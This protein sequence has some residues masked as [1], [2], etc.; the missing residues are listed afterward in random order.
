VFGW[1]QFALVFSIIYHKQEWQVFNLHLESKFHNYYYI[2][3]EE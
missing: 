2:T 3:S 1:V